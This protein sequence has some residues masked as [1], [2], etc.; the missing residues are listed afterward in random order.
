MFLTINHPS[1]FLAYVPKNIYYVPLL[2]PLSTGQE[3]DLRMALMGASHCSA[4]KGA[5]DRF[6][7][8]FSFK[9]TNAFAQSGDELRQSACANFY[10]R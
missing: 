9:E 5:L 7:V 6:V 10:A 2:R 8:E 4:E 3:L 1:D